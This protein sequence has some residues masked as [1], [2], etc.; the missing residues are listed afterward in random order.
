MDAFSTEKDAGPSWARANWP[1][2][3][4]DELN[5]GLDPTEAVIEKVAAAATARA[6]AASTLLAD[7]LDCDATTVL[8]PDVNRFRTEDVDSVVDM[9]RTTAEAAHINAVPMMSEWGATDNV[10]AVEMR[11]NAGAKLLVI[12]FG[13]RRDGFAERKALG[14]LDDA[15]D[16]GGVVDRAGLQSLSDEKSHGFR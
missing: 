13:R 8:G 5:L 16:A 4:L 12:A 1:V 3:E 11:G 6:A 7:V 2:A 9:L 15:G 14:D 10:R